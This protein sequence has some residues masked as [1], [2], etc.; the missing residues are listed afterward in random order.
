MV[1]AVRQAMSSEKSQGAEIC[2][3]C[4]DNSKST[5]ET[6]IPIVLVFEVEDEASLQEAGEE[7][8]GRQAKDDSLI[9]RCTG[10]R[11]FYIMSIEQCGL[12]GP[13]QNSSNVEQDR[14]A[15]AEQ[16]K[17]AVK[18]KDTEKDKQVQDLP[19]QLPFSSGIPTVGKIKGL[20]HLYKENESVSLTQAPSDKICIYGIPATFLCHDLVQFLGPAQESISCL[21]IVRM[22]DRSVDHYMALLKLKD[23]Q[24]A[25]E[26]YNAYNG[27]RY[28]SFEDHVCQVVFVRKIEIK[29]KTHGASLPVAG[30]TELPNCPVC[31]EKMDEP[32]RGV[33]TI[34]CN[35]SFHIDCLTK[36]TD[37]T[38]PICRYYQSPNMSDSSICAVCRCIEDLWMCLICGYIGC[39]RYNGGHAHVHFEETQHTYSMQ[40]GTQR[41]WDYIGDNYVHRLVQ[42]KSDGKLVQVEGQDTISGVE[43]M[44]ALQ[45]E[46]T[47]L[48][49]SQ[50][51]SQRVY[52]EEKL[53]MI[54]Q[55]SNEQIQSVEARCKASVAEGERLEGR[56]TELQ[57]EKKSLEKK[58]TSLQQ[59]LDK[60]SELLKEEKELNK[61]LTAD[62]NKWKIHVRS[63]E[64]KLQNV[65]TKNEKEI[66]SLQDQVRDL[67][68][69]LDTQKKVTDSPSKQDIQEGHVVVTQSSAPPKKSKKKHK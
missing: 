16:D 5:V 51:E 63:L 68:F 37:N 46:Y 18:D 60:Q 4:R 19:Q 21:Q 22:P 15:G 13:P 42:N 8:S 39:G 48:L 64:D 2:P 35:H 69:Y 56:I 58:C 61:A 28:S 54:E 31:L 47:Y 25:L 29:H 24:S 45:L 43:K 36:W 27:K 11:F 38:C 66:S 9:L 34:L 49:T 7:V 26:F 20:L 6:C 55:V 67:M 30:L 57:K 10:K 50:L 23:L 14:G 12:S 41:V 3:W 44:D 53:A 62:Q 32:V 65:V 59:R 33:L 1:L 52:F 40:V 17:E